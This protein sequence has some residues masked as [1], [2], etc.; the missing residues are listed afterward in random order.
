MRHVGVVA[1]I[2]DLFSYEFRGFV[3]MFSLARRVRFWVSRIR[4]LVGAFQMARFGDVW[5]M[6]ICV[7]C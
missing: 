3:D 6:A 7:W 4:W 1:S 2:F 5:D